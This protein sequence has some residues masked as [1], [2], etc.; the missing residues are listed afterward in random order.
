MP[1]DIEA[2]LQ[3]QQA[4]KSARVEAERQRQERIPKVR[5]A[6]LALDDFRAI[7]QQNWD[8]RNRGSASEEDLS[9]MREALA[10][11]FI[12]LAQ[13]LRDEGE[14]YRLDGLSCDGLNRALAESLYQLGRRGE[15]ASLLDR[16]KQ[17]QE[18]TQEFQSEVWQ[19][20]EALTGE[21]LDTS[22]VRWG[23]PLFGKHAARA[24][25]NGDT[26][27]AEVKKA[28]KSGEVDESTTPGSEVRQN[29]QDEALTLGALRDAWRR[30][31]LPQPISLLTPESTNPLDRFGEWPRINELACRRF[32]HASFGNATWDRLLGWL[33]VE[34][35][36]TPS[37]IMQITVAEVARLLHEAVTLTNVSF[38]LPD[39]FRAAAEYA[40]AIW[41]RRP[42]VAGNDRDPF[43]FVPSVVGRI[44]AGYD[45][46]AQ[47]LQ[48]PS[49]TEQ[50]WHDAVN[51]SALSSDTRK[52]LCNL[53][54]AIDW[55]RQRLHDGQRLPASLRHGF[56][57][58]NDGLRLLLHELSDQ[59]HA[60]VESVVEE[61]EK[62][63]N[64]SVS[65]GSSPD[66]DKAVHEQAK[67]VGQRRRK[68]RGRPQDTDPKADKR[69]FEAWH[70]GHYTTYDE[71]ACELH[72][73][74]REVQ[75]A[76][77]RHRKRIERAGS[78]RRTK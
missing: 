34:E 11:A 38:C 6:T 13:R 27:Q 52:A 17:L 40:I 42:T 36:S 35:G 69:I 24:Q 65:R 15:R 44:E 43:D 7:L 16:V 9:H 19:I 31:H 18:T 33:Q 49:R 76:V 77:E 28:E 5:R 70:S 60:E 1:D 66:D 54:D 30:C 58:L 62:R 72:K 51:A 20:V 56:G 23:V 2:T 25:A 29:T 59:E 57:L 39:V 61:I 46:L 74:K 64:W 45:H 12:R 53:Y 71:L 10:D 41:D 32:N 21:I 67:G 8:L 37:E 78:E 63:W 47:T 14:E 22:E 75:L 3:A 50:G 55:E 26:E 68:R 73:T 4:Q 48:R